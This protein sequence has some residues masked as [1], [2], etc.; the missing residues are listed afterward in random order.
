MKIIRN[1]IIGFAGALLAFST[2]CQK[3]LEQPSDSFIT[4]DSV[5][6]NPDNAMRSL[7]N[8][9][10][11]CVVDGF[12]T[13][14]GGNNRS[15]A[16]TNDGLLLAA[17]DEGDQIGNASV[18]NTFTQGSWGPTN[19]NEFNLGRVTLG[20]RNA[21]IFLDN[22]DKVPFVNGAQFNWTPQ[23]KA[24]TIGEAK[25]LR[26]MMHYEMMIRY[27]GIPITD[28]TP[29][30]VIIEEGGVKKAVVSPD[31]RRRPLQEVI[32]FIVRSCDEA[33]PDLPNTYPSADLGR[34]NK[35][36]ALSLKAV[37][38]L[39]AASPL[40]SSNT[41]PVDFG[42]NNNLLVLGGNPN[43]IENRWRAA[44]DANKAVIDWA[45]ANGKELLDDASLGKRE[46]YNY[47]TGKVLDPINKEI[48]HFDFSR[49]T[50]PAGNNLIRWGCPIY[51]SWGGTVM[52]LPMNFIT[53]TYRDV[54]GNDI[55]LPTEGSFTQFKNIM[56][57]V[58]P[59][60][61]ATAWAP[62]F[63]YTYTGLM[64]TQ[65]GNDTAKFLIRRGSPTGA[66]EAMGAGPQLLVN[67]VPNGIHHKKFINLVSGINGTIDAYWPIFRLA[68]FYLNYA[69][70]LNEF[71]PTNPDIITYLN[72]IRRRGGLPDLAPGNA[73][74][75]QNFGNKERMRE[76][77]RRERAIEL[78]GEEHRFFDVRRWKIAE[79]DGVMKGDF[80][81]FFLFERNANDRYVN[82]SP[83]MTQAQRIAN[84]N[85]LNYRIV[86]YETRIF[87][88][89]HYF[90][91]FPVAEVN[92]GFLVQNPGW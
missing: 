41:P 73:T 38:L 34:I 44:A 27:G 82:P 23:L 50:L 12:I 33:I 29:Q 25:V 72:L 74:Y 53:K 89:K 42:A 90:Y 43:D 21:C 22:V 71:Q 16:G 14:E 8:V 58:E 87:E 92:K 75:D 39:H 46:S 1:T 67:G 79:Q 15:D 3:Y 88:P 61:H 28:R 83:T 85:R 26:A 45:A 62:G 31:A 49:S 86:R 24:Q 48:I 68:E 76:V 56:R 7:F 11:T 69:E 47:A 77:I 59:R 91:P 5:F 4:V 30:I 70:A 81:S 78:Y 57:R 36:A 63:Q 80:F 20:I 65:G 6:N 54:N 9:Y 17:S 32:D 18:A 60:F 40:Y 64:N 13:G 2:S 19:Q 55:V 66:F 52:A 51:Y 10:A 84:D 37:T 35:G